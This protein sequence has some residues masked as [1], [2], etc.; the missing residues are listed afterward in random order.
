MAPELHEHQ[1]ASPPSGFPARDDSPAAAGAPARAEILVA[2]D[3]PISRDV[4]AAILEP[5]GYSL[6]VVVD[7]SRAHFRARTP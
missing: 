1:D 6:T 2:E 3:D 4:V 7:G 5:A